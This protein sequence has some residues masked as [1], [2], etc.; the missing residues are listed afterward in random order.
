MFAYYPTTSLHF[1]PQYTVADPYGERVYF[2]APQA[3]YGGM[4]RRS[5]PYFAASP[6]S[7]GRRASRYSQRDAIEEQIQAEVERRLA[8]ERAMQSPRQVRPQRCCHRQRGSHPAHH[9]YG[10]GRALGARYDDLELDPYSSGSDYGYDS[11]ECGCY[12]EQAEFPADTRRMRAEAQR[13]QALRQQQQQHEAALCQRQA[14]IA[15]RNRR[16]REEQDR[17]EQEQQQRRRE[18]AAKNRLLR[19]EQ[20]R[21]E[22]EQQQRRREAA[23][24]RQRESNKS[25]CRHDTS[26]Q[27][28]NALLSLFGLAP[29]QGCQSS[30]E[31]PAKPACRQPEVNQPQQSASQPAITQSPVKQVEPPKP[32]EQ[33][34]RLEQPKPQRA[35][36][37]VTVINITTPPSPTPQ[38][39]QAEQQKL[40]QTSA[41]APVTFV[42]TTTT[43][44]THSTT[45]TAAGA[46]TTTPQQ[47]KI[48]TLAHITA[49]LESTI[50][51]LSPAAF[52]KPVVLEP[53]TGVFLP[54]RNRDLVAYEEALLRLLTRADEVQSEGS[55]EVRDARK[56]LVEEVTVEL[57]KVDNAKRSKRAGGFKESQEEALSSAAD[58]PASAEATTS[59]A[60][61]PAAATETVVPDTVESSVEA[62][63][64]QEPQEAVVPT[65]D[66]STAAPVKTDS[67][68]PLDEVTTEPAAAP[69]SPSST[70]AD[71]EKTEPQDSTQPA[72]DSA[73]VNGDESNNDTSSQVPRTSPPS[74]EDESPSLAAD[75]VL[76]DQPQESPSSSAA[77]VEQEP[78][79]TSP[80]PV[81]KPLTAASTPGTKDNSPSPSPVST[82]SSLKE[83]SEQQQQRAGSPTLASQC[84][85]GL[86]AAQAAT[87]AERRSPVTSDEYIMVH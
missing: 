48:A 22:L 79:H 11:D 53:D 46:G 58:K 47:L 71:S 17:Q 72:T 34:K 70:S 66:D 4:P 81:E 63:P 83:G 69:A 73:P 36:S 64:V 86:D 84:T 21:Q 28:A 49:D 23:A 18:M 7:L 37:P 35:A 3:H 24:A 6:S 5:Q 78:S 16:L 30:V 61:E 67:A 39:P 57:E 74:P 41:S 59:T 76:S 54:Q 38:P 77:A 33:P 20:H 40:Q 44:S 19:E 75:Q 14:E 56:K 31:Q 68:K 8:L 27:L 65:S 60:Q 42:T 85:C 87:A 82:D 29:N 12:D 2:A 80:T 9:L 45:T 10:S 50:A 32:V 51:A 52:A 55:T 25:S 13:R 15:A 26:D 1:Q 43:H 62:A